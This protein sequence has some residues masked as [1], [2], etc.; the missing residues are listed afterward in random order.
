[1][2]I[3][4][5]FNLPFF[6]IPQVTMGIVLVTAF[7]FFAVSLPEFVSGIKLE[8]TL[9]YRAGLLPQAGN[10]WWAYFTYAFM[11]ASVFHWLFNVWYLLIF[12][13]VLESAWGPAKYI[14]FF[15]A[16]AV[17]SV[18]PELLIRWNTDLPIVGASGAVAACMGGVFLLY[19]EAKARLWIG[20]LPFS[21]FPMSVFVSFRFL[22]I[23]W[24]GMQISGFASHFF[25]ESSK[26]A[27][28]THLTGFALGALV[29]FFAKKYRKE[30]VNVDL[31]GKDL[32]A[33]YHS[34]NAYAQ[35]EYEKA[36]RI[37]KELSE[38]NAYY[39][40]A[41]EKIFEMS[42]NARQKE[43]SDQVFRRNASFLRGDNLQ[44]W[45][46]RYFEA[47]GVNPEPEN[48]RQIPPAQ[49]K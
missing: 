25:L 34:M 9:T 10:P 12:G 37:L 16:T 32:E 31:S 29:G 4:I 33:L 18:L 49:L 43:L 15:L 13:W 1:M 30:F 7:L 42:L 38:S 27:Y 14:G 5:G 41:Q 11:H 48:D 36:N 28:A 39:P 35:A 46:K 44:R 22:G 17:L 40:N 3:P 20:I 19:P 47:Y 24:L 45:R 23:I 21:G 2:F 8:D 6:R 26:V